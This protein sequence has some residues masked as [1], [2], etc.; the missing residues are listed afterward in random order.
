[1]TESTLI[2]AGVLTMVYS[3]CERWLVT[4]SYFL[5]IYASAA[6]VIIW[7]LV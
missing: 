7:L 2:V 6:A 3:A 4:P 5:P 1:M